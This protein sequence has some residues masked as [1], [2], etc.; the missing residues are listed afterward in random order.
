MQAKRVI[1]SSIIG[2]IILAVVIQGVNLSE[3]LQKITN[4]SFEWVALS[5][6][7][8]LVFF[9]LRAVRWKILLANGR[10]F[11]SI[12]HITQIGYLLN[13]VFPFHLGEVI[14]AIILKEKENVDIGYGISS[15]VV[16]R[17]MDVLALLILGVI[18]TTIIPPSD[19]FQ[20]F[21]AG[22][23]KNV[24]TILILATAGIVAFAIRPQ[25]LLKF[26]D[27]TVRIRKFSKL[28]IQARELALS[29]ANGLKIMSKN[30]VNFAASF[31]LTFLIWLINFVGVYF[32]FNSIALHINPMLIFVGFI[33]TTLLL[34]LPSS[35]GYVG[36]YEM[37][38]IAAFLSLGFTQINEIL[39]VGI[40]SHM[41]F[42][43]ISTALGLF[44]VL[45]LRLSFKGVLF[46]SNLGRKHY[47]STE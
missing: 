35:P 31:A 40:L 45:A 44:G 16:E 11:S 18:I 27:Y 23:I 8:Y 39:S 46:K 33:A 17:V 6:L 14:R 28:S 25:I 15:T 7:A 41:I 32:L 20:E 10:K 29:I 26:L 47:V 43:I 19:G 24:A 1:F 5:A 22:T 30:H 13:N 12:F 38:W 42:I 3:I 37:F 34:V 2:G 4:A 21:F 36:T 9:I